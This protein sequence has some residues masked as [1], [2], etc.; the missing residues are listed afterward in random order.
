[1]FYKPP[2]STSN[3]LS[4]TACIDEW[5]DFIAQHSI[6]K[7]ELI[8]VGDVNLHFFLQGRF[9]LKNRHL[10][11]AKNHKTL[12]F[13]QTLESHMTMTMTMTMKCFY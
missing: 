3:Q 1:M 2:A 13:L 12:R 10:D 6:S 9:Y 7:S 5:C 8:I 11:D 4:T